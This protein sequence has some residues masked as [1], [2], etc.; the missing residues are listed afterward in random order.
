MSK[1]HDVEYNSCTLFY[2]ICTVFPRL[3]RA[4]AIFFKLPFGSEVFEDAK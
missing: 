1:W 4:R 2:D 3:T